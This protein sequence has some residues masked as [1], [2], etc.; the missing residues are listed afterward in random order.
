MGSL[1]LKESK[2]KRRKENTKGKQ[3]TRE[4]PIPEHLIAAIDKLPNENAYLFAGMGG[5]GHLS[6]YSFDKISD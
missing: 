2:V 6:R 3:E 5:N 4:I 1:S